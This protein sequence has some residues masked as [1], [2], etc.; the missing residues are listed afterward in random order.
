MEQYGGKKKKKK[1]KDLLTDSLTLLSPG[2]SL[3]LNQSTC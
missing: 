1:K 3:E 2:M